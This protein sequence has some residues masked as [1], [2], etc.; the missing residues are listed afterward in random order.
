VAGKHSSQPPPEHIAGSVN[1]ALTEDVGSGDLT[2][3]LVP[4]DRQA[5]AA[6]IARH[7]LILCG[8]AW[9][10]EVFRQLN[11]SIRVE[12]RRSDG[13]PVAGD[14]TIC[15]V[16]GPARAI[17]TGERTAL[18]F[19]QLLSG[20][21]TTT[22]AFVDAVAGTKAVVL[23]TRKT[24]PGLRLAQKYAVTCGGG[25]NHRIGLYDAVLIKENHISATGSIA[26]AVAAAASGDRGDIL[27]EVEIEA[28][29]QIGEAL[30]TNA[31]RILLDNFSLPDLREAV[32]VRGRT[33]PAT[34]LEASGGITLGNIREIAESGVDFISIGSLTKDVRAADL[35]M[36][37]RFEK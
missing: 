5:D 1:L 14:D 4:V 9:F 16:H 32:E 13:A 28:V 22:K 11:P 26:T 17:L 37:F 23:D 18:N 6:V 24:L 21:A 33:S 10:D 12:W 2:A 19:L 27:I 15:A 25:Q 7:D 3:D 36:L 8:Q 35:S 30:S 20:T 29:D 34:T 31:G